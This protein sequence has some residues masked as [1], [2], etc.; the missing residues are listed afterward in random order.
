MVMLERA[1]LT[2]NRSWAGCG[3]RG[4]EKEG[5]WQSV[6]LLFLGGAP[7]QAHAVLLTGDDQLDG[8]HFGRQVSPAEP[9]PGQA[10]TG[11]VSLACA[12]SEQFVFNFGKP[13]IAG[14]N[15]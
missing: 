5:G 15:E 6:R 11:A 12:R 2:Q 10:R 7:P 4:L 13:I 1:V 8:P 3:V 14:V 9:R